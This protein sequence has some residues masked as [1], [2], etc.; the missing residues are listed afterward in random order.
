MPY[1]SYIYY[2]LKCL[3]TVCLF[4]PQNQS[5]N[6]RVWLNVNAGCVRVLVFLPSWGL[7]LFIGKT[8]KQL[9]SIGNVC[10]W[11]GGTQHH[12]Q[13]SCETVTATV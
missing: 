5:L 4:E 8:P 2:T 10:V 3:Y 1:T 11:G 7:D 13:L 6:V 9:L 12:F